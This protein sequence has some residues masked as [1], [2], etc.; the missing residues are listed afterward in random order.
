MISLQDSIFGGSPT[1]QLP[2]SPPSPRPAAQPHT[3]QPSP[4]T[5]PLNQSQTSKTIQPAATT[6]TTPLETT[7]A[8]R[9]RVSPEVEKKSESSEIAEEDLMSSKGSS[10]S[11]RTGLFHAPDSTQTQKQHSQ[12]YTND[13]Q[14]EYNKI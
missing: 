14:G 8:T 6:H 12:E 4:P 13:A 10:V 3:K 1:H 2:S 9:S 5:H 7:H 11:K